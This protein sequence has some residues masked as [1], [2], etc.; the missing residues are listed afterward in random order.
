MSVLRMRGLVTEN[1][2]RKFINS[3]KYSDL[4]KSG[5]LLKDCAFHKLSDRSF[6]FV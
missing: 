2:G 4:Y 3:F 5:G 6:V 1:D